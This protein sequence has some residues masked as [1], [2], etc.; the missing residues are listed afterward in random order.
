MKFCHFTLRFFFLLAV[1]GPLSAVHASK[2][3]LSKFAC[4]CWS[5]SLWLAPLAR[6]GG[7]LSIAVP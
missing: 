4:S 5:C 3:A 7:L 6:Y 2:T 1:I